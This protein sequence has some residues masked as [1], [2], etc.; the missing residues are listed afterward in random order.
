[1]KISPADG[2]FSHL[3]TLSGPTIISFIAHH[4]IFIHLP[5]LVK[6]ICT[7]IF[8]SRAEAWPDAEGVFALCVDRSSGL[9]FFV[10]F[11]IKTKSLT[12]YS[13]PELR[14]LNWNLMIKKVTIN[15]FIS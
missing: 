11:C 13:Y 14:L 15:V 3:P 9:D 8:C 2:F 1:M 6:K 4:R 10:T 5:T 12:N 7:N